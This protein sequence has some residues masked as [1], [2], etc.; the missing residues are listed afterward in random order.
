MNLRLCALAACFVLTSSLFGENTAL[1]SKVTAVTVYGDRAAVT[2]TGRASVQ[3]GTYDLSFDNLPADMLDQSVRVS[4]KGSGAS[5]LD[6]RVETAFLD[7]TAQERIHALQSKLQDL[8]LQLAEY[9]DRLT[10][11]NT[12]RDFILQIKPQVND[13]PGKEAKIPQPTVEEWQKMLSFFDANLNKIF[14]EQ[15]KIGKD[16]TDLQAKI[17]ALQRQIGQIGPGSRRSAK[18]IVVSV[19]ATKAGDIELDARYVVLDAGW[20]P[21]YDIRVSTESRDIE[22]TYHGMI[23]QSTGEDWE[24]VDLSLS[25]AHPDVGGVQP[26]LTPW[27]VNIME[28]RP[29]FKSMDNAPRPLNEGM[30]SAQ[31]AV[32]V[33]RIEN[34]VAQVETQTTS[35]L[36][37]IGAKSTVLS[38]NTPH[39]VTIAIEKLPASFSYSSSPKI[40]PFVYL[41]AV[42]SNSSDAP[43]IAG[44]ANIFSNDDFVATT[45]LNTIPPGETFEASLGTDPSITIERKLINKFTDY[46]G[47]FTKNVRVTYEFSYTLENHKKTQDTVLVQDQLPV[48]QNEKIVVEQIEPSPN[49]IKADDHG[50]L[51]W[52]VLVKPGEKKTWD[53]KF[54]VEYPRGLSVSGIE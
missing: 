37:H 14:A 25:T 5:I 22:L 53:L 36:F 4:G 27:Y 11:L 49:D 18:N 39:A 15:R 10:V 43:L 19:L 42:V 29:M 7:T 48:S 46:T 52:H 45:R 16:R 30:V 33:E 41:K 47:T 23:H 51:A 12:E 17:D 40:S 8:Q 38:D 6:V 21:H 24:N 44:A 28:P 32:S 1:P 20:Y 2:R 50:M 26:E 35:A 34:V 54:N 13:T 3:A 9:N 31:N